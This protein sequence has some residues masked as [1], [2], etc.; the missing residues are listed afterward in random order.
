MGIG[1]FLKNAVTPTNERDM[2]SQEL[3]NALHGPG[4]AAAS[5]RNSY[6][7][8][9]T[10]YGSI[11]KLSIASMSVPWQVQEVQANGERVDVGPEHDVRQLLERPNPWH[12]WEDIVEHL[13]TN[14]QTRGEAFFLLIG[15]ETP[16]RPAVGARAPRRLVPWPNSKIRPATEETLNVVSDPAPSTYQVT[17]K[18]ETNRWHRDHVVHVRNYDPRDPWGSLSPLKPSEESISIGNRGRNWNRWLLKNMARP[19]GVVETE[20]ELSPEQRRQLQGMISDAYAGA[21]NSGKPMVLEKNQ[22][23]NDAGLA[24]AE[25]DWIA[26]LRETKREIATNLGVDPALLGDPDVKIYENVNQARIG[27]YEEGV[28]P[29][30]EKFSHT[31]ESTLRSWYDSIRLE[32]EEDAIP[33]MQERQKQLAKTLSSLVAQGILTRN[34]AR[35]M[36]NLEPVDGGDEILVGLS[37]MPLDD[38]AGGADLPDPDET[39]TPSEAGK[40][41]GLS[42]DVARILEDVVRP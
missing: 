17:A 29:I 25:L 18:G 36:M 38:V 10:V 6:R 32:I 22:E 24:P 1:S 12:P 11:K 9:P 34:E 37:Q 4:G 35:D 26:G 42:D 21:R 14:M 39:E 23:W 20:F 15:P 3:F 31:L 19:P 41:N 28:L 40:R 5:A 8:N 16:T 27:L 7:E 30:L 2:D 33:A 13:I